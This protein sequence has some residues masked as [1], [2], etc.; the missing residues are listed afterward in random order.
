MKRF[1]WGWRII[2][3]FAI[4]IAGTSTWVAYAM[5]SDVDLVRADYYEAGLKEDQTVAADER[6]VKSGATVDYDAATQML[7]IAIPHQQIANGTVTFYRPSDSHADRHFALKLNEQGT[8]QIPVGN[9]IAGHWRVS[10]D[11]LTNGTTY[12]LEKAYT[13]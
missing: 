7:H 2:A 6:G 10:L 11:W 5:S 13:F 8:M 3:A 4:F 12:S 1:N 9:L